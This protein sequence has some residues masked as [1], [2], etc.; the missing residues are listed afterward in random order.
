MSQPTETIRR[1]AILPLLILFGSLYFVQGIIEPTACLPAQPVQTEL[2]GWGFSAGPIGYFF[3]II[4]I[5]WSI[6]PLFGVISD[7]FPL[8]G[9]RRRR[10]LLAGQRATANMAIGSGRTRNAIRPV[11]R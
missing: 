10:G 5:A 1:P 8:G 3:G 6:K 7:F 9:Y 2:R 11:S 4:G